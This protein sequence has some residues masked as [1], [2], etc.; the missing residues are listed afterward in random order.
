MEP[1]LVILLITVVL[2]IIIAAGY[3]AHLAAKKRREELAALAAELG[4]RFDPEKNKSHDQQFSQFEIFRRGHSRAAYNTLTGNIQ[5]DGR[6]FPAVMGDFTYKITRS[7]G[8]TTTTTTYNFSYLIVQVPFRSV[9]NLFIRRENFLDKIA[10]ALGF[11][12]IDFESSEFSKKFHVKCPDKKFAYDIIHPR[13]MEFLLQ[14]FP[15][16]IDIEQGQ[17]CLSEGAK[18]WETPQFRAMLNWADQF[19]DQWPDH[20]TSQLER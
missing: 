2:A 1:I 14:S 4:W 10:G 13:M 15:T 11:D 17:C 7:N 16:A 6:P 19:F 5:I 12:D 18:R 3:Y 9:P 20:V 8:K